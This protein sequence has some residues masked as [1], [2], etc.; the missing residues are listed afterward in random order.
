M[1]IKLFLAATLLLLVSNVTPASAAAGWVGNGAIN[2][3]DTWY[4]ANET[5]DWCGGGAFDEADLGYITSLTLAGQCQLW[6][7]NSADW[8]QGTAYMNY[9]IDDG[10]TQKIDLTYYQFSDNNNY[11]QSGGSDYS[12][13]TIDI[14]TLTIG[15]HTLEINFV[16]CDGL[17]P[18]TEVTATFAIRWEGK[19][20]S[21]E[22]FLI[23]S[24]K[25]LNYLS[26]L[27]NAGTSFEDEYFK[28]INNL[29]Y[30]QVTKFDSDGDG[31]ADSNFTPIGMGDEL[32]TINKPFQGTFDGG[33]NTIKN[34]SYSSDGVGVG[35][36]GYIYSPAVIKNINLEDC[37]FT[38]NSCVGAIVGN[39]SGSSEGFGIYNCTVKNTSVKAETEDE[40]NSP[41][42]SAGGIIGY[43]GNL[44]VSDCTSS[45][46]V[47][48]SS[49]VGGIAGL[50]YE[51][52]IDNC[53]YI[54]TTEF[55]DE[56]TGKIAGAR[57]GY[58]DD[59]NL[60]EGSEGTIKLTLYDD[61]SQTIK[62]ADRITYYNGVED[63]DV[64]LSGRTL[65]K[66]G[67]WN[68]L[69]LP[70]NLTTAQAG[71]PSG[72]M[73]LSTQDYEFA[74]GTLTLKFESADAIVAGTPYIIKWSGTDETDPTFEGVT[75][76]NTA[77][78]SVTIENVIEFKGSY[79]YQSFT[80]DDKTKLFLGADN[81][82]YYPTNKAEIG[83]CRAYFQLADGITA[84]DPSTS[85]LIKA[86]VLNFDEDT[87][88]IT[89][90]NADNKTT[91]WYD[92]NGIKLN[93]APA[94]PGMYIRNGQKVMIK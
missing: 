28:L 59:D 35:L 38:G 52:T 36:F 16:D 90:I 15:K 34:I 76:S 13:T 87:N 49:C 74:G 86:F 94:T 64:T 30:S 46:T 83:A 2:V 57:G 3:N 89:T 56:T 7:E 79:D 41:A 85:T 88:A 26:E 69:C 19:G 45:A 70:F 1:K 10:A 66:D 84:G 80:A 39:S 11:F 92:L 14:S 31:E 42:M 61:D 55:N 73:T 8:G 40:V 91:G 6:D 71:D 33:G 53:F 4:Y 75:I 58:D 82:L 21:S 54:G 48:G 29:D 50:L 32:G 72:L 44:I 9:T 12:T 24:I 81:T 18:T 43:C 62:N 63:V 77:A 93:E 47:S 67:D 37:S 17:K 78:S 5:L 68:T 27:V 25:G 23:S 60:I 22:P 65:Y 51:G 20:T